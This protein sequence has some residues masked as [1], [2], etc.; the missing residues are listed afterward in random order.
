MTDLII[1]VANRSFT[2][3]ADQLKRLPF[4]AQ[5]LSSNM[6][7]TR[8][9]IKFPDDSYESVFPVLQALCFPER[10][11]GLFSDMLYEDLCGAFL[12]I[13]K[14]LAR[15]LVEPLS[16]H[17][18]DNLTEMNISTAL[19]M[20]ASLPEVLIL[21]EVMIPAYHSEQCSSSDIGAFLNRL[22]PSTGPA[23]P[24][25][26]LSLP[27]MV[28]AALSGPVGSPVSPVNKEPDVS[29]DSSDIRVAVIEKCLDI[30]K[31]S[32]SFHRNGVPKL[33]ENVIHMLNA[34]TAASPI[35]QFTLL[36]MVLR[37]IRFHK[38][39]PLASQITI[40]PTIFSRR[41][42]IPKASFDLLCNDIVE[43]G[44]NA[45]TLKLLDTLGTPLF[46]VKH[47]KSDDTMVI[48]YADFD[49][50]KLTFVRH[51]SLVPGPP[52]IPL[53]RRPNTNSYERVTFMYSE[54]KFNLRLPDIRVRGPPSGSP[55]D[56]S[57]TTQMSAQCIEDEKRFYDVMEAIT[58]AFNQYLQNNADNIR[59]GFARNGGV[60]SPV[61]PLRDKITGEVIKGQTPWFS[62]KLKKNQWQTSQIKD[63]EGNIIEWK[64]I[65]IK[66]VLT[67][68][69]LN[70]SGFIND[71]MVAMPMRLVTAYLDV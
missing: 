15:T 45:L 3:P 28:A 19:E 16:Q 50:T 35:S 10:R 2:L 57:G 60:K 1:T 62:L 36:S 11:E 25:I 5:M 67:D 55:D 14:I 39:S 65:P 24:F 48:S 59:R 71:S 49:V 29:P 43:I 47:D 41:R 42:Y 13:Q 7:E 40:D 12:F 30:I 54:F 46:T 4:F 22:P 27:P 63:T 20:C 52:G 69:E 64:D 70:I 32:S 34:V 33:S 6:E 38:D 9:G 18:L 61:Q 56:S 53:D 37:W 26:P 8:T 66:A 21:P 68:V 23:L 44:N 58:Q 31:K 51:R 17:I